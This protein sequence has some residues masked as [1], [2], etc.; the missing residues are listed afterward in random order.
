[1]YWKEGLDEGG[2]GGALLTVLS[3][4]FD[5]IKH[6]LL[7]AKLAAYGFDLYSQNKQQK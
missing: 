2:L 4:V 6:G 5:C 7:I 1:M 3:R